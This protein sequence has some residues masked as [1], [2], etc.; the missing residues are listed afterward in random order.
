MGRKE[1]FPTVK[2]RWHITAD[3]LGSTL[4]Y[5]GTRLAISSTTTSLSSPLRTM[6]TT[7]RRT[8]TCNHSA[9]N[10]CNKECQLATLIILPAEPRGRAVLVVGLRQS[11]AC[12]DCGFES[13]QGHG[14]LCLVS[15]VYCQVEVSMTGRSLVQRSPIE[16][17]CVCVCE[18]NQVRQK[19]STP[20]V[21]V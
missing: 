14:C 21:S 20:A 1:T 11:L 10:C 4:S 3:N 5:P 7:T 17:V 15:V 16:Y 19:S 2:N 8:P 12:W 13:H 6:F 9:N 18:C